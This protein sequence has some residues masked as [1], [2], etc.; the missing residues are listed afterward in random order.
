MGAA[1]KLLREFFE[2]IGI[3]IDKQSLRSEDLKKTASSLLMLLLIL[4][5]LPVGLFL[6]KKQQ[7]FQP[8][9][10]GELIQLG[11]GGC[12]RVNKDKQKAVD[13]TLVPLK[14]ANPFFKANAPA[15]SPSSSNSS[16]FPTAS[17]SPGPGNSAS[18]SPSP[19]RSPSPSTSPS[20]SPSRSPSAGAGTPKNV[21]VKSFNDDIQLALNSIKQSGGSVYLPSGTYT[22]REKIRLFSNTTLF[23]DGMGETVIKF[24]DG[25]TVSEMMANDS[26]S[27]QQNIVVRDLTLQGPDLPARN[28]CCHG[29]KLENLNGGYI[30]NVEVKDVGMDGIYLGYKIKNGSP[31]G[32]RNVRVTGCKVAFSQR[33]QVGL[34]MGNNVVIDNCIINGTN[35]HSLS[36]YAGIDLEPDDISSLVT[37][38]YVLNNN[39]SN[40]NIGIALNGTKG[41]SGNAS[42]VT[43]NKVCFNRVNARAIGISDTGKDNYVINNNSSGNELNSSTKTSPSAACSIPAA[44]ANLPSAPAKPTTER[45]TKLALN[46]PGFVKQ[47][48]AQENPGSDKLRYRLAESEA[49]L[50]QAPWKEIAFLPR[51]FDKSTLSNILDSINVTVFAQDSDDDF[52]DTNAT[53]S[54]S[55]SP[56]ISPSPSASSQNPSP[57][58]SSTS[59]SSP[60]PSPSGKSTFSIGPEFINTSFQLGSAQIG[61]KQI[62]VEFLHPNGTSKVGNV[63]FNLVQKPPQILGLSCNL[64]ISKENLKINITGE[65][66]GTGIGIVESV[67]PAAKPE[68]LGWNDKE[69][70]AF[71]KKP[72]IPVNEG[73]R[74]KIKL[75]RTDGFESGIVTCAVDKSLVSLGARIFCREPGKFDASNIAVNLIYNPS[76]P[77]NPNKL[78]KVEEKVTINTDGEITNLKTKLQVGK[79]YAIAIKAPASLRR[80]AAFTA[81][82]GTTQIL[83]KD[84]GPFILPIGDIAPPINPDG[85]INTIDRAELIRQWRILGQGN[86]KLTGDFNRD[87]RVNSID[88]A[89]MRF[90][91]GEKDD[92][93][94][95]SILQ[96]GSGT[97]KIP[98]GETTI[99]PSASPSSGGFRPSPTRDTSN[100]AKIDLGGKIFLDTNRNRIADNEESFI[101]QGDAVVKLL[102]VPED[103]VVGTPLTAGELADSR[104]LAQ[105]TNNLPGANYDI[106][107]YVEKDTSNKFSVLATTNNGQLSGTVDFALGFPMTDL[108]TVINIPVTSAT[109]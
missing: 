31:E 108:S 18:P 81:Q 109:Q 19:S 87:S 74:F 5:L 64:D 77:S 9:A 94:P 37:N 35:K 22:I 56:T 3:E 96:S 69:I 20:P 78:S 12:I 13:C 105:A 80:S 85:R 6:I 32:V 82:E 75:T 100:S 23:G 43:N 16:V 46:Q 29:L 15:R 25:V 62:W 48:L 91:F 88:W 44:L 66:F 107:V 89:C 68:V 8:K 99:I 30:I 76:D 97:I 92:P 59:G 86:N 17:G 102:Q 103:H 14:L 61:A 71:L 7:I 10:A 42:T 65:R 39:V 53:S 27:G 36:V 34:V 93:I 57:S 21:N 41:E 45:E 49:A 24:A 11:D 67:S 38:S 84:G 101:G 50:G 40:S 58:P 60:S 72:N 52:L 95:V 79:N 98:G 90:D 106:S 2:R 55:P 73:Q 26:T 33:Q 83:S 54:P 1:L 28:G 4:I 63:N 47:V 70:N 104:I 51:K